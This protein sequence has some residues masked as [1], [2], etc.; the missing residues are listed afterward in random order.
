MSRGWFWAPLMIN[1][2]L[3]TSL[4][5]I[6]FYLGSLKPAHAL[7]SM[8]LTQPSNSFFVQ[9]LGQVASPFADGLLL[10]PLPR[11][12]VAPA[13]TIL[14]SACHSAFSPPSV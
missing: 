14:R 5:M 2:A 10:E 3:R 6:P 1:S 11:A 12:A 9:L 7:E 4:P 13:S 8:I